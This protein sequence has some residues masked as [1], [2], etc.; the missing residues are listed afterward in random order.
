MEMAAFEKPV[1]GKYRV[2]KEFNL[3]FQISSTVVLKCM[4]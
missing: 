2:D 1:A 4:Y 3:T